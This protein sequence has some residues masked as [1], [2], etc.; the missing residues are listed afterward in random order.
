M[1]HV[2]EDG[3]KKPMVSIIGRVARVVRISWLI[4]LYGLD[5]LV[6]ATLENARVIKREADLFIGI[7]LS[8]IGVLTFQ[9]SKY[10]DGN[11]ADY[12]SCTRPST[13]YYYGGLEITLIVVGV[14]FIALWFLKR[15]Q[16]AM[17][18]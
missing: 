1:G 5:R 2:M 7:A 16:S 13:Y 9:S 18:A 8:L 10:C 12:L 4:M 15:K 3:E 11:T 6:D 17:S 14:F